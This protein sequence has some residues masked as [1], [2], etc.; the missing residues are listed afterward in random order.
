MEI[1]VDGVQNHQIQGEPEDLLEAF[2]ILTDNL[3]SKRRAIVALRLNGDL[4]SPEDVQLRMENVPINSPVSIEI[5]TQ[6]IDEMSMNCLNQLMENLPELPIA[7]RELA[8]LFQSGKP[9]D[10][11]NSFVELTELWHIVKERQL[12]VAK[13]QNIDMAAFLINGKSI[14]EQHAEL[15]AFL[16]DALDTMQ[17]EDWIALGDLLEYELA[18]RADEEQQVVALLREQVAANIRST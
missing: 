13:T 3:H 4:I 10:A 6:D 12:L 15:N 8:Q 5:T 2:R 9:H 16:N 7:C 14:Q 11:L 1:I 17:S 18:P